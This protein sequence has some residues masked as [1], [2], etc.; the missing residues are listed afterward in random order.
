M[1][2]RSFAFLF[3]EP[4]LVVVA[5]KTPSWET[6]AGETKRRGLIGLYCDN[7]SP[8]FYAKAVGGVKERLCCGAK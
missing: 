7:G 6:V 1:G 5:T 8:V 3:L 4:F 2:R